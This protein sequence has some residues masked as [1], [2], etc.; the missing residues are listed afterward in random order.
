[1]FDSLALFSG[2]GE[3]P[4]GRGHL[5]SRSTARYQD[6]SHQPRYPPRWYRFACGRAFLFGFHGRFEQPHRRF[7]LGLP[8]FFLQ[9]RQVSA[10]WPA[11]GQEPSALAW[12]SIEQSSAAAR[13]GGKEHCWQH[14]RRP[15]FV[16][17]SEGER[18]TAL[19]SD[20]RESGRSWFRPMPERLV[21]VRMS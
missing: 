21:V 12:V 2:F 3:I 17:S 8:L 10:G 5:G 4:S 20:A 7:P 1:M 13:S 9:S 16:L 15:W 6:Q 19:H 18:G 11:T 14:G